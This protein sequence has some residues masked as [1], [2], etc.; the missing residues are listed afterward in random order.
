[1]ADRPLSI[2]E[3]GSLPEEDREVAAGV[4]L[5]IRSRIP[6]KIEEAWD[7]VVIDRPL[8]REE[9]GILAKTSLPHRVFYRDSALSVDPVSGP[10]LAQKLAEYLPPEKY[11]TFL[12][13]FSVRYFR[14]QYGER[15]AL[16]NFRPIPPLWTTSGILATTA[17][18]SPSAMGMAKR[19]FRF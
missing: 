15:R 6:E 4:L 19:R 11:D 1:M 7:G 14:G 2:L 18:C 5:H 9:I 16:G 10:F 13:H 17:W 8:S 3:V 12:Q